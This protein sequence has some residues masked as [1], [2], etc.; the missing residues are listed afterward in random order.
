MVKNYTADVSLVKTVAANL[1]YVDIIFAVLGLVT[2]YGM[3]ARA[4]QRTAG[5]EA[6]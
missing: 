1:N 2:A 4:E 6:A 3:L 5:G